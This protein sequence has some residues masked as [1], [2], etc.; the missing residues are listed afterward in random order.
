MFIDRR[1][2]RDITNYT[3]DE[4]MDLTQI[5]LICETERLVRVQTSISKVTQGQIC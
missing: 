5:N 2:D 3:N 1:H 4:K